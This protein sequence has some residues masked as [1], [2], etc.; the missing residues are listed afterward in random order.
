[1]PILQVICEIF[2]NQPNTKEAIEK[3]SPNAGLTASKI[4]SYIS[5]YSSCQEL[6]F[7]IQH[8][9]IANNVRFFQESD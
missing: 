1:M 6:P 9:Y 7:N 8:A 2:K 4:K 3:A 5:H